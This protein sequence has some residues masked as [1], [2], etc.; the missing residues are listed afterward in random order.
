MNPLPQNPVVASGSFAAMKSVPYR[1]QFTAYVL[2]MMA[3]NIEHVISYWVV[4]QKF[5]SPTLG[6]FA[7]LSH[8]LP[9]LLFS[10]AVGGLADRF[11]PRRIIQ[12]GMLLFIVASAGWGFFFLTDT[13]EMW[14]AMLLLVI[15][16]CAGVLWQTPNQ[17][18]LYDLV[19]PADLPSAVRLNA[20]ARYL[21]ILVGPAVGGVIM[22]TLGPSHGIIFN[23]LFYLPMLLWL[24]WAPVRDKSLAARRF[25][26]RGFAD[27]VLTIRA[28]GKQPVLTAMTWLAGLTSFMIGNAYHA[29]MPG[30]AGDLGHGD[31]GV[32]Y[33][34]LLAAD[35]AGALLA[36]IALES[37]GRLK[38]TPRTA[39]TLAML[40]SVA[41]LGFAAVRIYPVAIVLLFF[42][43]FF[44]LS[45]NTMA[46]ALVQLNAPHDIRGRVVGLYNMAGLGMRAFS[47]ITVGVFGAAIGIHWSLGLS[48]AVLL[49]LLVL[50][51]RR[52]ARTA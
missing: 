24:F 44:E 9:F 17:L 8:W 51:H 18:L 21:G 29:Q 48:A 4:F 13:I 32:S 41:L 2:A 45:F 36:G 10:V 34:V 31:P 23:T 15:H 42:A 50:L 20:M 38:G 22:L 43:G 49:A 28:I 40:W 25:A 30:F 33:S 16:G 1:L 19:G 37:W 39:I 14:H 12:C 27:I 26:V 6:G 47:G 35:A 5:H 52:G 7:V 3:D 46:Q 11:D